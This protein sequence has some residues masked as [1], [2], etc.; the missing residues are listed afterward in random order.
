MLGRHGWDI[1]E[2]AGKL[3]VKYEELLVVISNEST[4]AERLSL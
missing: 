2:V 4:K 3:L 1:D